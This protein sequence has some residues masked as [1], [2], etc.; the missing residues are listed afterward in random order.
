MEV[1][2]TTI[3]AK[4]NFHFNN[5]FVLLTYKGWFGAELKAFCHEKWNCVVNWAEENGE[6]GAYGHTH[7]VLKFAK[8]FQ[9]KDCRAFDL[10]YKDAKIHPNVKILKYIGA[11]K[12]AVKYIQKEGYEM[13]IEEPEVAGLDIESFIGRSILETLKHASK[14][15]D[16]PGLL[17]LH[18][19]LG[20]P[21]PETP[22]ICLQDWMLEAE[23]LL[24]CPPDRM[25]HWYWEPWGN[26]GKS[27]WARYMR[28]KHPDDV[29][30]ARN[31]GGMKDFATLVEGFLSN[32]WS[33]RYLILDLPR[34]AESKAIY[35]PLEGI[36]DGYLN[37]VKYRGQEIILPV[38]T[39]VVVLANFKPRR[40]KMSLDRWHIVSLMA[41][42]D[43]VTNIKKK[44]PREIAE[45][46]DDEE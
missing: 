19:A 30:V 5:K 1:S 11:Y 6:E 34:D 14:I 42:E 35:E 26:A 13:D 22:D 3:R 24:M 12:D 39:H 10:P 40:H 28:L 38:R 25:V 4:G 44:S 29:R 16:V 33:G 46:S 37:S 31:L 21:L 17:A 45:S 20:R 27:Y 15:T 2:N 43:E 41:L 36:K 32:E 8:S 9:T 7:V 18:G 23:G